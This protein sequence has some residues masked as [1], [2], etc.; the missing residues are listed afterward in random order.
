MD[1]QSSNKQIDKISIYPFT[2][3]LVDKD[4]DNMINKQKYLKHYSSSVSM[5]SDYLDGGIICYDDY[6]SLLKSYDLL[7]SSIME[8]DNE[9][10]SEI[11]TKYMYEL[12]D[13]SGCFNIYY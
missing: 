8:Y 9:N 10:K 2:E 3:F 12:D 6:P 7:V 11:E 5:L 13:I 1:S 4:I